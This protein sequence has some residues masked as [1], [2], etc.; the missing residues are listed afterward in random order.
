MAQ[1]LDIP[2]HQI[3]F[4][5]T[6]PPLLIGGMAMEWYGLRNAGADID[7]VV[8]RA[9][10]AGLAALH[11]DH[12]K[13]LHGDL[14]VCFEQFELWTSIYLFDY[15]ALTFGALECDAYRVIALDKLL[16]LKCLGMDQPK[17]AADVRLIAQRIRD[18][19]YGKV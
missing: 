17:N 10:Y 14:G 12:L 5:F 15:D 16:L 11:P 2:L 8:A 7:F 13:D 4:R 9:D 3:G 18:L 1:P 6:M 19:Q